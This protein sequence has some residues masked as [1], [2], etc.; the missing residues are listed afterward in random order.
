MSGFELPQEC[1][2]VPGSL[3]VQKCLK[4]VQRVFVTRI[5]AQ[6]VW[7]WEAMDRIFTNLEQICAASGAAMKRCSF[8]KQQRQDC[9]DPGPCQEGFSRFGGLVKN[10]R[11]WRMDRHDGSITASSAGRDKIY[12]FSVHWPT[13]T[14]FLFYGWK[15]IFRYIAKTC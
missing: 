5:W 15:P 12:R 4:V 9:Y 3:P 6:M 13:I 8:S 14:K 1:Q 11:S 7:D 2:S 10:G